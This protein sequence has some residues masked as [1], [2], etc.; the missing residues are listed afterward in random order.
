MRIAICDDEK[1][2]CAILAEKVGKI[3][4]DAETITYASGKELLNAGELPDILLLDIRM[5]EISGMDVAKILRDRDWR[6]PL[7]FITGEEDQVFNSFDLQAF[8]FLVK[9]V[10]DEKLKEVLDNARKELERYGDISGKKDKYIEIQSGTSHI[11]INL[12]KLLYAEVYDRKTILHMK[13][14]SIEYYGQLSALEELVGIDFY[15]IHRSYLV[16]MKYVERYDRTS[17]TTLG[18]DNIPIAR[19][20]YDGFLKAYMEYSRRRIDS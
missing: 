9:P 15:R 16:N 7:I 1:R 14:E 10:A 17:I 20:E 5:P 12:S 6:K 4:P 3:C 11:R 19:R 18:G 2:I 13:D 8:H